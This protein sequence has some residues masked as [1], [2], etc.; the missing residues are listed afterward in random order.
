MATNAVKPFPDGRDYSG[1]Q[2]KPT[3]RFELREGD[4][5]VHN[6]F[7]EFT[8]FPTRASTWSFQKRVVNIAQ[9]L[10]SGEYSWFMRQDSNALIKDQN[11]A[12]ILDTVRYIAT[13]R[14]KFSIHTWPALLTYEVPT[15]TESVNDR[16]EIFLLMQELKVPTELNALL[17]MWLSH[18]GGIYDMMYTLHMLFGSVPEKISSEAVSQE[19]VDAYGLEAINEDVK[20]YEFLQKCK[21]TIESYQVQIANGKALTKAQVDN[22]AKIDRACQLKFK[23]V[24]LESYNQASVESIGE[25]L[26]AIGTRIL[27][28]LIEMIEKIEVYAQKY[29]QGISGVISRFGQIDEALSSG[30]SLAPCTLQR[31][32]ASLYE[33]NEFVGDTVSSSEMSVMTIIST[34]RTQIMKNVI[35]QLR[36][37]LSR[38][39]GPDT[40]SAINDILKDH[41]NQIDREYLLPGNTSVEFR[42]IEISYWEGNYHRDPS[43]EFR[44]INKTKVHTNVELPQMSN[45]NAR[46][47]VGNIV[48]YL[49]KLNDTATA[50][51]MNT[52]GHELKRVLSGFERQASKYPEQQS[53]YEDIEAKV[54]GIITK[55]FHPRVYFGLLG[56]LA[57]FQNARARYYEARINRLNA[58]DDV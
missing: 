57:N 48:R 40:A 23:A 28:W 37:I 1:G 33:G 10:F 58:V 36:S 17:Q 11:Y 4:P 31:V 32:A 27:Q 20:T 56:K 41:R 5:R 30:A 53:I 46:R 13:G 8:N 22:L 18:P 26:K 44:N 43:S 52:L 2:I 55:L 51:T 3:K 16:R 35:G 49:D 54:S 7:V 19:A 50:S 42:G 45:S 47:N 34:N 12:F 14:R 24:G 29:M 6:L 15:G 9:E 38:G 25:R 21:V 39:M